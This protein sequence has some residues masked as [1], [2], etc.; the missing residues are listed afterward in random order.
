MNMYMFQLGV[1]NPNVINLETFTIPSGGDF[2]QEFEIPEALHSFRNLIIRFRNPDE[3]VSA[4]ASLMNAIV[5][6]I[7]PEECV[8]YYTVM[9][10]DVLSVVAQEVEVSVEQ[11]VSINNLID[12]N[13][14]FPGQML[15][16]ELE[17]LWINERGVNA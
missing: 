6:R 17:Q 8:E 16:I 11:L 9:S 5:E 12:A 13:V 3:N 15:C 2:E 1:G 4:S 10:G 7:T 14:L